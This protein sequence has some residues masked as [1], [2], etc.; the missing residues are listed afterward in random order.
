MCSG[1][2]EDV[3]EQEQEDQ[4]CQKVRPAEG[5]QQDARGPSQKA[6]AKVIGEQ[7]NGDGYRAFV[8]F[9]FADNPVA[10]DMDYE[11]IK[12]ENRQSKDYGPEIRYVEKQYCCR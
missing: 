1:V 12:S 6:G 2:N 10:E 5:V 7:V 9:V 3:V 8:R 11:E 4:A